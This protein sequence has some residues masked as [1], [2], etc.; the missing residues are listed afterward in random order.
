MIKVRTISNI[1]DL[2]G[3]KSTEISLMPGKGLPDYIPEEYQEKEGSLLR[4]IHNG[5][6][7]PP[8]A[9]NSIIPQ[10]GDEI[11]FAIE[12]SGF[13][14]P[15]LWAVIK[16]AVISY[17]ISKVTS[18]IVGDPEKESAPVLSSQFGDSVTYGWDGIKNTIRAGQTIPVIYGRHKVA[19]EII[20]LFT[21]TTSGDKSQLNM[22]IA[23]GEGGIEDISGLTGE[24]NNLTGGSIPSSIRING[25]PASSSAYSGVKVSTRL[26]TNTQSVM[27]AFRD[28]KNTYTHN[29]SLQYNRPVVFRTTGIIEQYKLIIRFPIGLDRHYGYMYY[30]SYNGK[31]WVPDTSISGDGYSGDG[32]RGSCT[33]QFKVRHRIQGGSW[34]SY[35]TLNKSTKTK[36][37]FDYRYTKGNLAQGVY[38]IEIKRMTTDGSGFIKTRNV[39]AKHKTLRNKWTKCDYGY[40]RHTTTNL[41]QCEESIYDDLKYPNVALLGLSAIATDHLSGSTP[42]VTSLVRGRKVVSYSE[43][44]AQPAAWSDNPAWCL[45]DMLLNV[46]YGLGAYI[47]IDDI[48][49]TSF[50]DFADYCNTNQ[51]CTLNMVFDGS[52][53]A[54]DAI[55]AVC[56][57]ARAV[58]VKTGKMIKVK[59]E[60]AESPVQLFT[61]GNIIKDSFKIKYIPV[62]DRANFLEI[63]FLNGNDDYNQDMATIEDPQAYAEEEDFKK[64]TVSLYGITRL[65]QAY[66]EGVF[67]LNVNRYLKRMIEFE[68]GIDAIACEAGDVINFQHDVPQWGFGGR[69]ISSTNNTATLDHVVTKESGTYKIRV[70]H[71]NDTQE[72]KTVSSVDGAVVTITGTWSYNPVKDDIY[73]YGKDDILVK[74]FR[75]TEIKRTDKMTMIISALEYNA[76]IYNDSFGDIEEEVY[77]ELPD[78]SREPPDAVDLSVSEKVII[79]PDGTLGSGIEVN[80]TNPIETGAKST[81]DIWYREQGETEWIYAGSTKPSSPGSFTITDDVA[82][83]E[84]YEIA[85]TT[86]SVNGTRKE[87]DDAPQDIVIIGGQVLP[88]PTVENLIVKRV[89]DTIYLTWDEANIA[90]LS[91]YEIRIGET[92]AGGRILGSDIKSQF[93]STTDFSPG[94]QTF[95][96]RAKNRSGLYSVDSATAIVNVAE[97]I[98]SNIVISRNEETEGWDGTKVNMTVTGEGKLR[99]NEGEVSG[100]Y[101][102]P[103]MDAGAVLKSRIHLDYEGKQIGIITWQSATYA[104]NSEWVSSR[105]WGNTGEEMLASGVVKVRTSEDNIIWTDWADFVVGEHKFQY[106]QFKINVEVETSDYQYELTRMITTADA[107]DVIEAGENISVDSAGA[108]ISFTKTF[109][110]VPAITVVVRDGAEG[111]TVK[112]SSKLITGFIVQVFNS[113]GIPQNAKVDW[114]ARGF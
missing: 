85:V 107:P 41:Y 51:R 83:G 70:R 46:R 10:D 11:I 67:R 90:D 9:R 21:T 33:V 50:E 19:G 91:G 94:T 88:P 89:G 73:A 98:N 39:F 114:V 76:S 66:R 80:F 14:V 40:K 74:P 32:R 92:W 36:A 8:D 106:L 13:V 68:A 16:Y 1:F 112:I 113:G 111:D 23:L 37:Q 75:V 34:S 57:T 3:R 56:S 55:N 31:T 35:V 54:W 93:F 77:T 42:T 64:E 108:S 101:T 95:Q 18:M 2:T 25:N 44:V 43:G 27:S 29:I 30:K 102:T 52:M 103:V 105:Q 110:K 59:F 45:L 63:Q 4:V 86:V 38:D 12:P 7:V 99:L 65:A 6:A 97:R 84:T 61:M 82:F 109:L 20:R 71:N 69:V 17:A 62:R 78:P 5:R 28:I 22:L 81:A 26:G 104:W 96:V 24:Q 53:V 60:Q 72:E 100:S 87:P 15:F 58:L 49:I 47:T 79:L 48:D